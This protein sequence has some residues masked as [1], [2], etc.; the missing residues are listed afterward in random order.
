MRRRSFVA[1]AGTL[2]GSALAGC[3]GSGQETLDERPA[4]NEVEDALRTAIGE[5]NTVALE[6]ASAREDAAS[7]ADLSID[8]ATLRDGVGAATG[9]LDDAA[10]YE[11]AG[12]YETELAEARAYVGAVEGLLEGSITLLDVA[13]QL[14]GLETTLQAQDFDAAAGELDAIQP[15]V[16]DARSTTTGAR[17]SAAEI[18]AAVLDPYGAKMDE[19]TEGLDTVANIAIGTDE[20]TSGYGA[21][22]AGRDDLAAGRD[23]LDAGNYAAASSSF[24]SAESEFTTATDHFETARAETDGEL[25]GRIDVALCRSRALTDA[26]GHFEASADAAAAGS[27][28][29][30]RRQQ[31]EGEAALQ[32]AGSC[33][34]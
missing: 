7:F 34:Q 27:R 3:L 1:G 20:L 19:L 21:L 32:T 14:D 8:A 28:A 6:L 31:E 10:E 12:D 26:A 13:T 4:G 16:D 24:G 9:A 5:A 30:S 25:S 23:A 11:A 18:D 29:E 33:G 22:L 17:S 15:A 2:V